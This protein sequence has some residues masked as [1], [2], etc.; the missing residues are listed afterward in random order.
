MSVVGCSSCC[1]LTQMLVV[2][3]TDLCPEGA[4]V[5]VE[6]T[7]M[8]EGCA[9]PLRVVSAVS[10]CFSDQESSCSAVRAH[11]SRASSVSWLKHRAA[12][13]LHVL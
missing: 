3:N 7:H 13:E 5:I 4:A 6:A 8:S 9:A 1:G 2:Q 12:P 11:L 10:G